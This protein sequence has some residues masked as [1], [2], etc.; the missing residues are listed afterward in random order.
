MIYSWINFFYDSD[1]IIFSFYAS[2]YRFKHWENVI[3]LKSILESEEFLEDII[4]EFSKNYMT[5]ATL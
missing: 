4:F 2:S 1:M 5:K 3:L